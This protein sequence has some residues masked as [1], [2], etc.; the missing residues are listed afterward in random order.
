MRHGANCGD[1]LACRGDIQQEPRNP[2][3]NCGQERL[4]LFLACRSAPTPRRR[5][6]LAPAQ[7]GAQLYGR[8]Q[9]IQDNNV[10]KGFR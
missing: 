9:I 7:A 10:S 2:R 6:N 5:K 1:N 3:A 8:V 4:F